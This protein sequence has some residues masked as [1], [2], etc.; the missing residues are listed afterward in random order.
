MLISKNSYFGAPSW[1]SIGRSTCLFRRLGDFLS[2][3][4]NGGEETFDFL[5][6]SLLPWSPSCSP[7][8]LSS[9]PGTTAAS[10]SVNPGSSSDLVTVDWFASGRYGLSLLCE[11]TRDGM[12]IAHPPTEQIFSSPLCNG[13][14]RWRLLERGSLHSCTAQQGCPIVTPSVTIARINPIYH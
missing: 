6:L 12:T 8:S 14:Y 7:P 10:F 13:Q 4:S 3:S 5:R 1:A 9:P 2:Q 11:S